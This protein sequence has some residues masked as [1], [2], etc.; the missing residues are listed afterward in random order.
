M[1]AMLTSVSVLALFATPAFAQAGSNNPPVE[2]SVDLSNRVHHEAKITVTY[3]GLGDEPITFRMSRSSPGRYAVHEFAK[4]VYSVSAADADGNP[5]SITRTDPYSWT[6]AGHGDTVSLTYTLYADHGDGTYSQV[7]PSHAHF[8][9]PSAFMWADGYDDRPLRV[10]FEDFDPSWKIATQLP[11]APGETATFTAPNLQYFMDSPTELSNFML[12]EW[13]VTSGGHNYTIRLAIHH[14][15]T[16]EEADRFAEM[17][18]KVVAAQY[19]IWGQAA[20]YDYGVYTFIADY[21]PWI[22]GDGMEHRN[23]T[24]I[25]MPRG[26]AQA[27]YAQIGTLSHEFFHSWNVERL[28]PTEL[29][30]FD[31]TKANPTPSL[32]FAEGFTQYYGPVALRRSGVWDMNQFVRNLGGTL[33]YVINAPGRTYAGPA[34]MSLRAPFVDAATAIDTVN[35]NIFTSYY[36]YGAVIA[37]ALDLEIRGKYPGKTLDGY[38]RHMWA[39]HGS[40]DRAYTIDDLQKGLGE[41]LNDA[42]F[43]DDF[44]AKSIHGNALPDFTPLLAQAGFELRRSGAD[45]AYIGNAQF[46]DDGGA[47]TVSSSPAPGTPLYDAG[48]DTSDVILTIDGK[49]ITSKADLGSILR[50]HKPG[51]TLAITY[52]ER[53]VERETRL[54]IGSDPSIE[55]VAY[56]DIGKTPTAEQ[57]AFRNAWIGSDAAE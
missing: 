12:R 54:T 36:P 50:A 27:N 1:R 40:V 35:P 34:E 16:E 29:E 22:D 2:Y 24:I 33:N 5:L 41:Y 8:N 30:P 25:A 53:D 3:S 21:L 38:M 15:G 45:S 10:T 20:P 13:Q 7:D 44:F 19:E 55:I 43:A 31:F 37:L 9:M 39:E 4:N 57:L 28:R 17:A 48:L 56:E 14:L 32:W 6:V 52:R 26:L 23:S 47:V 49:A 46:N 51:D 18:K 42:A 11:S